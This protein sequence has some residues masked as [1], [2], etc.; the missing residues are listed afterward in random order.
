MVALFTAARWRSVAVLAL[1]VLPLAI[2]AIGM[3]SAMLGQAVDDVGS[4]RWSSG[5][6]V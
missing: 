1:A 6:P 3:I 4:W 5:R 2:V